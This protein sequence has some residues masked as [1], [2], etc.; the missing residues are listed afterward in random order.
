M[1]ECFGPAEISEKS[2]RKRKL[3]ANAWPTGKFRRRNSDS[4][5]EMKKTEGLQ[6]STSGK[7]APG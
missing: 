5:G 4:G 6:T 7:E 3:N 2:T 1:I